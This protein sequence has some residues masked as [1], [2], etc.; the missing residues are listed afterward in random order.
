MSALRML[1]GASACRPAAILLAGF[2]VLSPRLVVPRLL[3]RSIGSPLAIHISDG[4]RGRLGPAILASV[5]MGLVGTMA[6]AGAVHD[7]HTAG[8]PRPPDRERYRD[9]AAHGRKLGLS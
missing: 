4:R 8:R 5:G 9:R 3:A 6:A 7:P 1:P 2:A